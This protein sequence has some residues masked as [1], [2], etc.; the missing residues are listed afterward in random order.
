[1]E[2]VAWQIFLW[3]NQLFGVVELSTFESCIRFHQFNQRGLR[4]RGFDNT[5]FFFLCIV[6]DLA[7]SKLTFVV[8]NGLDSRAAGGL[9]PRCS[10]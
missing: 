9:C 2:A 6:S 4:I 1:M 3:E 7:F 5:P 8:L 10:G